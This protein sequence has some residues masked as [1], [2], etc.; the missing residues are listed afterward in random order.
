M[1]VNKIVNILF[2]QYKKIRFY[3]TKRYSFYNNLK[4]IL[5]WKNIYSIEDYDLKGITDLLF[6]REF[7]K[8]CIIIWNN[9]EL[10]RRVKINHPIKGSIELMKQN[11]GNLII[12]RGGNTLSTKTNVFFFNTYHQMI[13]CFSDIYLT[14]PWLRKEISYNDIATLYFVSKNEK[15][16]SQPVFDYHPIPFSCL[17]INENKDTYNPNIYDIKSNEN[18]NEKKK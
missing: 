2:I 3:F 6:N 7:N 12:N 14:Q 5:E 10:S 4:R 17:Y 18:K 13:I 11:I 1:N 15:N 9:N 8:V 16:V